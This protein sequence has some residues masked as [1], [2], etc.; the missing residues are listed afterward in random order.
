MLVGLARAQRDRGAL[1]DARV[2]TLKAL[3]VSRGGL[4]E[5]HPLYASAVRELGLT[6]AAAGEFDGA[7]RQLREA[8]AIAER[9]HGSRHPDLAVFLGALA[10]FYVERRDFA[11]AEALYSRSL[12]LDDRFW[13]DVIEIGSETFKAASMATAPDPIPRLLA[14]Q[15]AAG[16]ELPRARALA[17]EAVARRKGR[18]VEQAR[19]WRQ[20]LE[21]NASES[22]RRQAR[23]WQALVECRT[24]LNVALGYRDLKPGLAGTCSLAG[25]DLEGR[26]ERL[27]GDL[28]SR[29]TADVGTQALRAI[30]VLQER[31][32]RLEA[33]LNREAGRPEDTPT[34]PTVENIRRQLTDDEALIEFVSFADS[35]TSRDGAARRYG[36]FVL[37]LQGH[38]GWTDL[39]P[40]APIDAAVGD[41]L[42]AARDWSV[43]TG[44]HEDES[45][46]ASTRTARDAVVDLSR[47][48]WRPL[49]PLLD[50]EPNIRRLRI[51]PDSALNLV[52]FEALSDGRD[53]IDRFTITYVPAGRDLMARSSAIA[54]APPVVVVSPGARPRRAHTAERPD[55]SFRADGLAPLG[56]A[57]GEA[58]D[59]RRTLKGVAVYTGAT[60]TERRVK[61]LHAPSLLHIVGHGVVRGGQD[62]PNP[63][64]VAGSLDPS[65]QAMALAAIVLEE[66]YGRAAGSPDDGMLTAME[67]QNVDL[68]GT[69]ML[70]LSQCQMASGMASVGEGV[71][72]MRRAAAIAGVR[73]FVAPLWN[74]EDS[75][76]RRLM[77]RFYEGLAAGETRADA[78]RHAKLLVR[79]SS[80]T[81]SFLYWAPVILSGS[82]EP[83][84]ASLFHR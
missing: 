3:E 25:T 30:G 38:L 12:E 62:C 83:L 78:L 14:F 24:S 56:E 22:V 35:S 42:T 63:P 59:I 46:R 20:R 50:A 82:V 7:E 58:A 16:A 11:A 29:W 54:S 68:R 18:I 13:R 33:T 4:G 75:V 1:S 71:Y 10:D 69:Q 79:R 41:L 77:R 74:V 39:G 5:S 55:V 70:V 52:P 17:F 60:A 9:V 19:S 26:Y 45:A 31:A 57:A 72:G 8:I 80:G 47:Q 81:G 6:L 32:E 15:A 34:P 65:T 2:T 43:S 40:A 37:T 67:L 73:T 53:L 28:R 84:P 48:V 44:N 21:A 64:C 66:A 27:L 23:E 36:A 51:A 49:K 61:D 76:Q